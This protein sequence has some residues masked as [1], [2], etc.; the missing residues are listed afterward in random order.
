MIILRDALSLNTDLHTIYS[1]VKLVDICFILSQKPKDFF[2]LNYFT[3]N[4]LREFYFIEL[5]LFPFLIIEMW[6]Q[7]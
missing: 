2:G 1:W 4:I 5:L 7:T 3:F 6:N